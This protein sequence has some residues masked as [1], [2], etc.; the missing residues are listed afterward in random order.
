[1]TERPFRKLADELKEIRKE[2]RNSQKTAASYS[3]LAE[4]VSTLTLYSV[5]FT[6]VF[7]PLA[8]WKLIEIIVWVWG[9]FEI[10]INY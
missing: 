9:V 1:M 3:I 8:I 6:V 10:L 2:V 4:V 5:I 7:M